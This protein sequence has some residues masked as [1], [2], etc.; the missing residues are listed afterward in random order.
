VP[1]NR[2]A[3]NH[4]AVAAGAIALR[5]MTTLFLPEKSRCEK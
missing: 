2:E 4:D 3:E 5:K 1:T